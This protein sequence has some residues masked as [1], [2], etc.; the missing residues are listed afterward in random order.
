MSIQDNKI[1]LQ[2]I[3]PI[4]QI[5]NMI[6]DIVVIACMI[7]IILKNKKEKALIIYKNIGY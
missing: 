3:Y 2:W 6:K 7:D 5:Y 4:T 1:L